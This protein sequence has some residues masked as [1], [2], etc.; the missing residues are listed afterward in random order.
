MNHFSRSDEEIFGLSGVNLVYLGPTKY[1]IIRDIRVP[2]TGPIPAPPKSSGNSTKRAGKVKCRN[3]SRRRKSTN[4]G[5]DNAECRGGGCGRRLQTLSK[6][7]HA[8][9]GISVTNITMR[10]VCSS[11]QQIDYVSLNDGYEDGEPVVTKK[12]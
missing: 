6:S 4:Q 8:N 3:S 10:K 1:G 9:Y 12:R 5:K 7:R 2:Q 11:R